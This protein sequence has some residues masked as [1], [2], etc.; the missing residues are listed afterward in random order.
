MFRGFLVSE[1]TV[2]AMNFFYFEINRFVK[3]R[4]K[5]FAQFHRQASVFRAS[6]VPSFAPV[7]L[8]S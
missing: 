3:Q 4:H 6:Q 7:I 2:S 8:T 5:T 1:R